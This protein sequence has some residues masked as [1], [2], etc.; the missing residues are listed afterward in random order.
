MVAYSIL[1]VKPSVE[2]PETDLEQRGRLGCRGL[3][4]SAA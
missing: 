3:D 4:Q 1:N 2:S